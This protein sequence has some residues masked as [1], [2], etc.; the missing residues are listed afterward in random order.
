MSNNKVEAMGSQQRDFANSLA[1]ELE[2][3]GHGPI[4]AADVLDCLASAD[5][6]LAP[7]GRISHHGYVLSLG[8]RAPEDLPDGPWIYFIEAEGTGM[9]KIGYTAQ[10]PRSRLSGLQVGNPYLLRLLGVIPG[11][12]QDELS[13]H[14]IYS[15]LH[16]RGDWFRAEAELADF[17]GL[18]D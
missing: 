18:H 1:D 9:V 7:G 17:L 4:C 5:L 10:P 11:N 12:E 14:S 8:F 15:H 16:V 6:H 2:L 3:C 13:Q